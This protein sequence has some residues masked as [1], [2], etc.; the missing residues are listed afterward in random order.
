MKNSFIYPGLFLLV[1]LTLALNTKPEPTDYLPMA[2][3][4]DGTVM[5]QGTMSGRDGSGRPCDSMASRENKIMCMITIN[6]QNLTP[7]QAAS[8]STIKIPTQVGDKFVFYKRPELAGG[9]M[10]WQTAQSVQKQLD[11][12]GIPYQATQVRGIRSSDTSQR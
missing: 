3:T 5:N 2:Y 9:L 11:A 12:A 1:I 8:F 7:E 4:Q 10:D 6:T